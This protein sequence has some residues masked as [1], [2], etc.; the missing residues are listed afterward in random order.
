MKV[1][2]NEVI[3]KIIV[4]TQLRHIWNNTIEFLWIG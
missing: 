4:Q 1:L 2:Q 3:I